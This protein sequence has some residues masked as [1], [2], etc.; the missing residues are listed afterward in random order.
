MNRAGGSFAIVLLLVAA[1]RAAAQETSKTYT[2]SRGKAIV[3][4]LG[5]ASFADEIVSFGVGTPPPETRGGPLPRRPL[6]RPIT[7]PSA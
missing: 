4:P 3:F 5:D 6:A 7:T 1:P 2:D